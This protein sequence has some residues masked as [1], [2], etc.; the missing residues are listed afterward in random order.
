MIL[1]PKVNSHMPNIT[2]KRKVDVYFAM[3]TMKIRNH[4]L[5][6]RTEPMLTYWP[7]CR[8]AK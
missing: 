5:S 7:V 4:L 2:S 3:V 1:F 6:K 8:S